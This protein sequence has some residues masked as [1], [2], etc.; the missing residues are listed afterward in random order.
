[1]CVRLTFIIRKNSLKSHGESDHEMQA[2]TVSA[3]SEE[4]DEVFEALSGKGEG[5]S[6]RCF[7][8]VSLERKTQIRCVFLPEL[9]VSYQL[10]PF[11]IASLLANP[12]II[13]C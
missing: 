5:E 2:E 4:T 1:M 10:A 9:H 11:P 13:F 12:T 6:S 7:Q 3:F 8:G